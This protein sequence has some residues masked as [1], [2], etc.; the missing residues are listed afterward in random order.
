MP[1]TIPHS[2]QPLIEYLDGLSERAS[3]EKL[4]ELLSA[5]EVSLGDLKP[6][7]RFGTDNYRRNLIA[8]GQWFHLLAICW[9]SGQRSPIHDHAHSTCGLKIIEGVCSET[10]F[11]R[12]PCG[13]MIAT[14]T[15]HCDQGHVCATQDSDVHQISNVQAE[16]QD[17]ITLHIYSPPL[18]S[19]ATYSITSSEIGQYTPVNYEYEGGAGI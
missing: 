19:M 3:V 6:W 14:Q 9:R 2:L 1:T 4:H 13:Q 7:L 11:E 12:S 8:G 10:K 18:L 5:T 16:G 17:L 15:R